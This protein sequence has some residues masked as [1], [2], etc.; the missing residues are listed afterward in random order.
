VALLYRAIWEE[1]RPELLDVATEA[2]LTWLRHKGLSLDLLPDGEQTG[3]FF[4]S[5]VLPL[6]ATGYELS[7]K[8]A[9]VQGTRALQ[10]R[11]VE[12]RDYEKQR[13]TT[14]FTTLCP[15]NPGGAFWVDVE[16]VSADPFSRVPFRAPVLVKTLI[17]E[18]TDPRVGHVR[19]GP[20]PERISVAGLAGLIVNEERRLPLVVFSHDRAGPAVT[21]A[22]AQAAYDHLAGVAQVFVLPPE[23]VDAFKEKV[24]EDLAVWGG[25]AR[26]YL[27]NRGSGGLHPRRHRYVSGAV[28]ARTPHAAA[29]RF[30][31]MLATTV[32]ATQAP[33]AY[34][35]VRRQLRLGHDRDLIELLDVADAELH[36]KEMEIERLRVELASR[37]GDLLDLAVDNED[38][39]I[40]NNRLSGQIALIA[41]YRADGDDTTSVGDQLPD[42]VATI[43]E[44]IDLATHLSYIE[45]HEDAVVDI[46]KLESSVTVVSWAN[47]I[48]RGL[49][50]LNAYAAGDNPVSGGF[51]EW[52]RT[53]GSPWTWPASDKKLA[54]RESD[55]VMNNARLR[56]ARMLPVS[57][58]IDPCGRKE[59][60]A[61]LKIAQGG[62]PLAPRI[63][64]YDDKAGPTGK[65]HV[66]FIG[67]HE[68]MPNLSAN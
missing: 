50:A 29:E 12:L 67:P 22:R 47:T 5:R 36:A 20:G 37:E 53:S 55:G 11:L 43:T 52:C 40:Q 33:A 28:A 38:L 56:A 44:A 32:P 41:R 18:G 10:I 6:F 35:L 66:G 34:E 8:R 62:G 61:H 54:M 68:N 9:E 49:R 27:P 57:R 46:E 24:G 64:F 65:V 45:I 2:A 1:D 15:G 13:W 30:A 63:Y 42:E 31:D 3:E 39:A 25:G 14:T 21:I 17:K 16:R 4:D 60:V 7:A 59:M 58:H 48:W 19:L 26:L 23:D 51:Y